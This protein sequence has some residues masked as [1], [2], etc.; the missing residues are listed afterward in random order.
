MSTLK[1]ALVHDW[2]TGMRGGEKCLEVLCQAFPNAT[3]HTL[4]HSPGR[5]SASIERMR[6][7]TSPL[8]RIP[9]IERHYRHLLPLMPLA[10]RSWDV[11]DVD[12]VVSFSHCVAKSVRVPA[13]VPHVSYC[14]TPMRY[15]WDG[16]DSYMAS[17]VDRPVRRRVAGWMLDRLRA[18]DR[19]S[20]SGVTQ[21]VAISQTIRRRIASCYQRSSVVIPPPVDTEFYRPGPVDRGDFYLCVSALVPYKRID[22]A[23]LACSRLGRR[24]VVIGEGTERPGL[25]GLAGPG[26][27]FLGWQPDE[28]IRDHYRRC[29]ALLFPGEEDFGIVPIEA[30]A[31]GTPVL[32]LGRGG[33]AETVDREVGRIH[34]EPTVESLIASIRDWEREG[35]P[36]D[37]SVARSRA[38]SFSSERFRGRLLGYLTEV[39]NLREIDR[40]P[41]VP[42]L[43]VTPGA[44]VH[45]GRRGGRPDGYNADAPS[46]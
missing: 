8:Q 17:W 11:G 29:R 39:L 10:A 1:V 9:G 41:P 28:V 12:L 34:D 35:R 31:C 42:H 5:L 20:A 23:I 30:L 36:C 45:S 16:R 27:E 22:Q 14:F 32:A 4:L 24:L 3:V 40:V 46:P 2:L 13:G 33:V 6:I 43:P 21:F 19:R 18:W 26:V 44:W 7:R 25:Q 15:A 37:A 38:E